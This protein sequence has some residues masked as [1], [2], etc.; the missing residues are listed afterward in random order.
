[1]I[2]EDENSNDSSLS[3]AYLSRAFETISCIIKGI[4]LNM[5]WHIENNDFNN[6]IYLN[7]KKSSKNKILCASTAKLLARSFAIFD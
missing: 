1:M 2:E 6:I 4:N 7:F 5:D 3:E